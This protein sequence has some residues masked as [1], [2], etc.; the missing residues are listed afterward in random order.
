MK[1]GYNE[2]LVRQKVLDAQKFK[3]EDLLNKEK[4]FE[5]D[6]KLT[7]NLT[8][9]AFDCL[10]GILRKLHVILNCDQQHVK[11]FLTSLSL[12][13]EGK[14]LKD[15]LVRAKENVQDVRINVVKRN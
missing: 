12:V 13:F 7:L 9:P 3:R 15:L 8:Y 10:N 5:K 2:R 1:R 6:F 14:S 11:F 4:G